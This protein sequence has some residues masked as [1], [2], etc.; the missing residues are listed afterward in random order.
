MF[1]IIAIRPDGETEDKGVTEFLRT[2]LDHAAYVAGHGRY[3]QAMVR[4]ATMQSQDKEDAQRLAWYVNAYGY[5]GYERVRVEE[6][7]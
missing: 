1:R 3:Y 5:N 2:A 4:S 6:L 7:L